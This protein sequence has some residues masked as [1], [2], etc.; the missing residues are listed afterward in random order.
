MSEEVGSLAYDI[1]EINASTIQQLHPAFQQRIV[2]CPWK[3]ET[4]KLMQLKNQGNQVF[5]KSFILYLPTVNLR[6]EHNPAFALAVHLANAHKIPLIV[7]A[8]VGYEDRSDM[9]SVKSDK[10]ERIDYSSERVL[11]PIKLT[12]RR[13]AF[14]LEALKESTVA[15][16]QHGAS[17]YIRVHGD[18]CRGMDHLSLTL[19]ACSVVVDE[20]YIHPYLSYVEKVEGVCRNVGKLCYRVDGS[21]TVP[22][23]SILR[24][25]FRKKEYSY[26]GVPDRAWKWEKAVKMRRKEQV[27]AA[28]NGE[29]NAPELQIKVDFKINEETVSSLKC[30][31][32][33]DEL[34][35]CFPPSWLN[36]TSNRPGIRPWTPFDLQR[37]E[38]IKS[39]SVEWLKC[40]GINPAPCCQTS[41]FASHGMI[42][43]KSW[44]NRKGL[45]NYARAR[46][47]PTNPYAPSRMSCYLNLGIVSIFKL[48][49]DIN[50]SKLSDKSVHYGA[51]KFEEEI[52]KWREFSYAYALCRS[53]DYN[54]VT[55]LP[56]WSKRYLENDS[57]NKSSIRIPTLCEMIEARTGDV[58]WDAMQKYLRE[59]GELHN[60]VRMT[61]G[62]TVVHWGKGSQDGSARILFNLVYLNDRFALDGISP[63]SY[64]G[65]LWCFGFG[66]K[67][68]ENGSISK[69]PAHLYKVSADDFK[70]A[71]MDVLS[72]PKHTLSRSRNI[73]EMF[74]S[75]NIKAPKSL[76]G[77]QNKNEKR[78]KGSPPRLSTCTNKN[79][80]G[81]KRTIQ[82][83]FE[84]SPKHNKYK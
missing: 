10:K 4:S 33:Q 41:G 63:P 81:T 11:N 49:N 25:D 24:R 28:I 48:V 54:K 55:C 45:H 61:W 34:K 7:L 21:T 77:F 32:C 5:R 8:V 53:K 83:F 62:K 31:S 43:W 82:D 79:N 72:N 36:Q 27:E 58:T 26:T 23:C 68:K 64:C 78:S 59:T 56:T 84:P 1:D 40:D 38:C 14:T 19:K 51:G 15:W 42:R 20:P 9:N 80:V 3:N 73:V 30:V 47:D 71:Q 57:L 13:L 39:W 65:I 35:K 6:M 29:F 76:A 75:N 17:V 18:S 37:I 67:P 12:A 69:K 60:N 50:N 70:K 2:K 46:N 74:V 22:P 52:L 66:D 44:L 16:Q